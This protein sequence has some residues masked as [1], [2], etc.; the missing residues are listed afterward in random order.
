[1]INFLALLLA[2]PASSD[3][4]CA[5][6]VARY[7]DYTPYELCP[8]EQ[9]ANGADP[10]ATLA[11]ASECYS[12][13]PPRA[14]AVPQPAHAVDPGAERLFEPPS[15]NIAWD[16][17]PAFP[18]PLELGW[19]GAKQR[20]HTDC[21]W[22]FDFRR[23]QNSDRKYA[24]HL[25]TLGLPLGTPAMKTVVDMGAGDGANLAVFQED[26]GMNGIGLTMSMDSAPHLEAMSARGLI[27]L[28][29]S[30]AKAL[31]FADGAFDLLHSRMSGLGFAGARAESR[32]ERLKGVAALIFEWDRVVRPGGYL[33]QHGWML[34][35]PV[36][37]N[38]DR[39]FVE[40]E[41]KARVARGETASP[42]ALAE[43]E[44]FGFMNSTATHVL[45]LARRLHWKTVFWQVSKRGSRIDFIFQKPYHRK[46]LAV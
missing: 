3:D 40:D 43:Q 30:L 1:M 44:Y 26:Y 6:L 39:R 37:A 4:R 28:R 41:V 13:L 8:S 2:A 36:T 22:C 42:S 38:W 18:K 24:A 16:R 31:P 17:F 15:A 25:K 27:G 29:H 23:V 33:V 5:D 7:N 20:G 12:L 45:E 10:A 32:A 21:D 14:C 46:R 35:S 19:A 34:S 9:V 11:F